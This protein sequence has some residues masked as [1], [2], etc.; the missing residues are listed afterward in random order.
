MKDAVMELVS[1][2]FRPE[3]INRI[4]ETVV[5]HALGKEQ[6]RE[7]AD[8]QIHRVAHRLKEH[9]IQISITKNALDYLAE[10]GFDPVYGARPL[11]RSIQIHLENPLAQNILSGNFGPGDTIKV[12]RVKDGDLE[13]ISSPRSGKH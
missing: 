2:H 5:F 11:K 10:V 7:I 4:D 8:I 6:I 12:D 3:F 1:R 13:F 9:D